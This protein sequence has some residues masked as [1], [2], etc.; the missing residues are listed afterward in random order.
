MAKA[1]GKGGGG[2][3]TA[4]QKDEP[5]AA[6]T[7]VDAL[8]KLP[9]AEFTSARNALSTTLKKAGRLADSEAVKGLPKPSIP[10]WVVNQL[11]WHNRREFEKLIEAGEQFRTAQATHLAGKSIDVREPLNA[12]RE[13]LST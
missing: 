10:A 2:R 11:Y 3:G 13:A 5:R 6:A 7:D 9:L 1:R 8:F 12:R 4:A